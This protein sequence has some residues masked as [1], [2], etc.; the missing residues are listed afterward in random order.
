MNPKNIFGWI[1]LV[2]GLFVVG[3]A[4][5]SSYQ[6]FTAKANFP[7]VFKI[8]AV[9][10]DGTITSGQKSV[11][12]TQTDVQV[13]LQQA[14]NKAIADMF[15]ADSVSKLLNAISWSMFAA[16]L[17]YAGSKIA[18]IGIKLIS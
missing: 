7:A 9:A 5:N 1:L 10:S 4:I 17:V 16:F 15:P 12:A 18:E 14:T 3:G 6:Y 11:T 13:Q 2:A 8:S